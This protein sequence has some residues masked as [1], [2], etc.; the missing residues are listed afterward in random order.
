M[1]DL[2]IPDLA[3]RAFLITGASTGIGAAV[4]RAFGRQGAWVAVHYN[5]SGEAA[6]AVA[7]AIEAAGGRAV[8]LQ[9]DLSRP[10]AAEPL[11]DKAAAHFGR[12]EGLINNAGGMVAR[13]LMTEADDALFDTVTNLNVRAS[14]AAARAAL[15]HFK[16]AGRGV[17]INTSSV[18]ARMGGGGGSGLYS[19]AKGFIGTFTKGLATELGPHGIRVN[20]VSPGV[21]M[22]R[23]RE[24]YGTP[25][26]ADVMAKKIP[27]GRTGTAEDLVGAYLYLASD[28]LSGYVTGQIIEVNGGLLMP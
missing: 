22:T 11:V 4:A 8:T 19:A 1:T 18:A 7:T 3:G 12:L 28:L 13:K 23:F 17:V 10:G 24:R 9:A 27:L 20:A 25:E 15:P 16:Q 26:P 6:K 21:T 14:V 5:E 2:K